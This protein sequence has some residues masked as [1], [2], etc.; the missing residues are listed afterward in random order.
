MNALVAPS[1]PKSLPRRYRN[2][3]PAGKN[4]RTAARDSGTRNGRAEDRVL[5]RQA[6]AA[7]SKAVLANG[8]AVEALGARV[9]NLED[10]VGEHQEMTR[11][12]VRLL[13]AHPELASVLAHDTELRDHAA[14]VVEKR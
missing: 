8:V 13:V 11:L 9:G 14:K 6:A 7:Q 10:K 12:T 2:D 4:S 3:E 5:R 1:H